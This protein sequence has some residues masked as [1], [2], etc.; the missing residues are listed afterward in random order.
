MTTDEKFFTQD[1]IENTN[2]LVD[3]SEDD[4][5]TNAL[6]MRGKTLVGLIMPAAL[7]STSITFSG[8][9]TVDGTFVDL[10]DTSGTQISVTVAASRYIL[11][12]PADFA[13]IRFLKIVMGSNELADRTIT[14]VMRAV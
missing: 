3:I 7:T 1:M 2:L 9:E 13:S 4:D 10:Y 6:D 14:A 12:D 11:I 8:C 5:L